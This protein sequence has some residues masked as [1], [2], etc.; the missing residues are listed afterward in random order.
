[1]IY[2]VIPVHNRKQF[3]RPCL[4]SLR[5]QTY[6][7]F[8]VIIVDDGSTDGT[9]EMVRVEF[10]E[11]IL[12]K[13]DGNLWWTG[14]T[15]MGVKYALENHADYI[16]TLNDD[17]IATPDFIEK[18][19]Y[20]AEKQPTAL[21]GA[22]AIDAHT[23]EP[24]YG[25]EIINWKWATFNGL[26]KENATEKTQGLFEVTHFPGRGL[27]IPAFV[28]DKIGYYD[29]KNFPHYAADY[30]FTH[31]AIRAGHKVYCNYD[32]KL[33]IYPAASG[34]AANR[35]RKSLTN[36]YMHLFGIKGGGNLYRFFIYGIK[37]CPR[38]YLPLF[39]ISGIVRRL[40]GYLIEWHKEINDE[41]RVVNDHS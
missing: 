27:L 10:P 32:A 26:L 16:M 40:S 23:N 4:E 15:N 36:Y 13:G 14:A 9:E 34:D 12:L 18:M 17:T 41:G 6:P 22:L 33:K 7:N 19:M 20:W 2:I 3:T 29:Q 21:L 31:R 30:D 24:V 8:K 25:G 38:R 39:L 28:F 35:N 1:M 5:N 11:V 37:N